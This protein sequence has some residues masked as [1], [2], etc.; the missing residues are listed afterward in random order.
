[1]AL[2]SSSFRRKKMGMKVIAYKGIWVTC[3]ICI[4]D[5]L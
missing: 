1:V 4:G 3:C 5:G 2:R